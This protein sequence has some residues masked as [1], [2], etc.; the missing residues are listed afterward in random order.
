MKGKILDEQT[1]T[2]IPGVHIYNFSKTKGTA[3]DFNGEFQVKTSLGDTL[4]FSMIGY[5]IQEYIIDDQQIEVYLKESSLELNELVV[6]AKANI[7]DIDLRRSIASVSSI[8]LDKI[9]DRPSVNIIEALQGQ[10]AG[11]FVQSSGELGRPLKI[12][13]RGTST[14]PVKVEGISEEERALLDNRVNQPLFVLDGQII[15]ADAF[16]TLNINDIQEIKVLKDAAA[17]ALYGVKAANGVI[18]ITGK[19]GINGKTENSFSFQQ[20]ITLKG[21]PAAQMMNS[22]EKLEFERLSQNQGTPGYLYSEEFIRRNFANDP[23]LEALV[24]QGAQKLDSL[25]QINTDWFEELARVSTYQSYNLSTRGG[26]DRY[27]FYVSGNYTRQGGKFDGNTIDR[28]TGRLSYEYNISEDL[29]FMLNSGFGFSESK[30]PHSSAYSPTELIYQLNSYEKSVDNVELVSFPGRTFTNLVNQFS[31]NNKDNRFNF[32]ATLFSRVSKDI[33]LSSIVG[34][35]YLNSGS[36]SIVPRDAFSELIGIPENER[37]Q[38]RKSKNVNINFSSNTRIN[39]DKKL[40]DHDISLSANFDYFRESA[41]FI[42]ILGFG[43]PSK[44][45]SGAGINNDIEGLRRSRTSSRKTTTAQQGVGFSGLYQWKEKLEWYASYK[46]DG[47]SLLPADKRW[48]TFWSTGFGY[49][50]SN[51]NFLRYSTLISRAKLRVTYGVTASLAGISASQAVPTFAY[52]SN[53]YQGIREFVLQNLFNEDLKP[54]KNTSIN[55]GLDL[56]IA[57]KLNLRLEVYRRRTEE[58][59]LTAPI[60]PSNGFTSQLRN[61]GVLDNKG[62]ELSLNATIISAGDF[63]WSAFGNISYNQN[64]IVDLYDGDELN[65]SNNPFPDYVEGQPADLLYGLV[66]LGIHPVDGIPRYRRAD[67]SEFHGDL[68]RPE[69]EDFVILGNSTPPFSGGQYHSFRYKNWQFSFDLYFTFGGKAVL[70]NGSVTLNMNDSHRNAI[71]GQ[72]GRTWFEAGDE[73]KIYPTIFNGAR[74]NL[75]DNIGFAS[76]RTVDRTDFVRLN[77]MVLSYSVNTEKLG[78]IGDHINM[79]RLFS[80]IKNIATWSAFSGG[81]PESANLSGSAQPVITLGLNASF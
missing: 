29:H 13:I 66:D 73:G 3:A 15:S 27:R 45:N 25:R 2:P 30:T 77:S 57:S 23:N 37:G 38:V 65:L 43:L 1:K 9:R 36:L 22:T 74:G 64:L 71:A 76:T 7:N 14:L 33:Q 5:Q 28:Y 16:A 46:L 42:G 60:A 19:R 44:L 75:F 31:K 62:I 72:I 24:L 18:E 80:Q 49:T 78:K 53:S 63:T 17:N 26:S 48:N 6:L 40:G 68:E 47:S 11:V 35:D 59:L 61:V 70:N 34:M 79:M 52:S 20:G 32:A 55:I 10:E 54:E 39:F 41:D 58:M 51:E 69:A 4:I 67:N 81:D 8:A 12:R 21:Q 50:L 56:G